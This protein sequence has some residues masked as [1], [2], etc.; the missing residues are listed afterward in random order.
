VAHSRS[1]RRTQLG[2]FARWLL[3]LRGSPEAIA[4]GVA[5]GMFIAWT[6]TIGIQ[7]LLAVLLSTALGGNRPAAILLTGI[8]NPITIPPC[9][10]ITY[11]FGSLV[12]PGPPAREVM[13]VLSH[14]VADLART[15]WL[16]LR[17]QIQLTAQIG[18]DVAAALWIGGVFVGAITALPAYFV[19][20]RSVLRVQALRRRRRAKRRS[21]GAGRRRLRSKRRQ[22]PR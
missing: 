4:R 13:R 17:E 11:W 12:W 8:T 19:T 16:D 15:N 7:I 6:P 14:L 20:Y 18:G 1:L 2:S 9:Y 3:T 5:I 22:N 21:G 10:A